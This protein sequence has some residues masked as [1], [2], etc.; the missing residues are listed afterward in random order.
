MTIEFLSCW[1]QQRHQW[2]T[3][4]RFAIEILSVAAMSDDVER[5]FS[6][7]RR[8]ISWDRIRLG[9][10]KV[11]AIECLGSWFPLN[12]EDDFPESSR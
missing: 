1:Y 7:S 4:S 5:V 3:P 2:P 11:D 9:L 6:G 10:D 12:L 8:T